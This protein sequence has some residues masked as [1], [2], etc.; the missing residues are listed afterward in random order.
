MFNVQWWTLPG[1]IA[2]TCGVRVGVQ[3]VSCHHDGILVW[4]SYT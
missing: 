4:G 1:G 2:V 3:P